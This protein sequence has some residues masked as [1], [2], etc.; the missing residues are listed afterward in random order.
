MAGGETVAGTDPSVLISEQGSFTANMP[1][2][3]GLPE[4]SGTVLTLV[5]D[6]ATG[7]VTDVG[8]GTTAPQLSELGTV[9]TDSLPASPPTPSSPSALSL[10]R[11]GLR[12][13]ARASDSTAAASS[14][15]DYAEDNLYGSSFLGATAQIRSNDFSIPN[16]RSNFVDNEMWVANDE[17]DTWEEAGIAEGEGGGGCASSTTPHSFWADMRPGSGGYH[18]HQGGNTTPLGL[19]QPVNIEYQGGGVWFLNSGGY[20]GFSKNAQTSADLLQGGIEAT[21]DSVKT[22]GSLGALGYYN[23]SGL[24]H[25]WADSSHGNGFFNTPMPRGFGAAWGRSPTW[26]RDW[27]NEKC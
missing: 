19:A 10:N 7:Q 17:Q 1:V 23:R 11:L 3:N 12:R 21:E 2:P 22:C 4:P 6:E 16:I 14:G 13:D 26:F 9:S 24:V 5:V 20:S 18:C 25:G 8:L 27:A 15:H